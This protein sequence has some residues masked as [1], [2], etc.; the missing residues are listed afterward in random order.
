MAYLFQRLRDDRYTDYPDLK[1]N[2][3][4]PSCCVFNNEVVWEYTAP[5]SYRFYIILPRLT[6][7]NLKG[8]AF[9]GTDA[10]PNDVVVTQGMYDA[11]YYN[12]GWLRFTSQGVQEMLDRSTG[13]AKEC[14]EWTM[15]FNAYG[16]DF[17]RMTLRT[18]SSQATT[19]ATVQVEEYGSWYNRLVVNK[20]ITLEANKTYDFD[21]HEIN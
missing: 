2:G 6:T 17:G 18:G 12:N 4:H 14:S 3:T 19:T 1:I 8:V 20:Q 10:T 7:V 13:Y 9:D 21:R 16:Y 5:Q 15:Q 11:E